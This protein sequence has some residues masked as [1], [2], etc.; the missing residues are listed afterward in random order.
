MHDDLT[1][2][3]KEIYDYYTNVYQ[4]SQDKQLA[5]IE[6]ALYFSKDEYDIEEIVEAF[7]NPYD[8]HE[9]Y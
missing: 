2:V 7:N 8:E 4:Y 5:L 9:Y 3:R 1:A 6:T